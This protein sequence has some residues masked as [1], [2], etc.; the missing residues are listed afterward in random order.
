MIKKIFSFIII[1]FS[2]INQCFCAEYL[3]GNNPTPHF[4]YIEAKPKELQLGS[5][6]SQ[7]YM[8]DKWKFEQR[9]CP[10]QILWGYPHDNYKNIP[11]MLSYANPSGDLGDFQ[12][13]TDSN[14]FDCIKPIS[15]NLMDFIKQGGIEVLLA[16]KTA[17]GLF[18]TF[19][20][21]NEY[22]LLASGNLKVKV[23][24]DPTAKSFLLKNGDINS[25]SPSR[26]IYRHQEYKKLSTIA[27]ALNSQKPVL[28]NLENLNNYIKQARTLQNEYPEYSLLNKE[29]IHN[30]LNTDLKISLLKH[31]SPDLHAICEKAPVD[32]G[33][34]LRDSNTISADH[35]SIQTIKSA[36]SLFNENPRSNKFYRD[37]YL[38]PTQ[39]I[40]KNE[41]KQQEYNKLVELLQ[42]GKDLIH[43]GRHKSNSPVREDNTPYQQ[44]K[45]FVAEHIPEV[46]KN[47]F[48][49]SVD[50]IKIG[51]DYI[52]QSNPNIVGGIR[53]AGGAIHEV[54]AYPIDWI[55]R[56][57]RYIGVPKEVAQD[58]AELADDIV[59]FIPVVKGA[60]CAQIVRAEEKIA[61]LKKAN[62]LIPVS[63]VANMEKKVILKAQ[64]IHPISPIIPL[65]KPGRVVFEG[66]EFRAVRNLN[67][68]SDLELKI[69]LETGINPHD[70]NFVRLDGHHH[71]QKFHRDPDAFIVE[72]P[73]NAHNI[74][75]KNQHP[76]GNERGAGLTP[77]QRADWNKL[78][79]KFNKE[80]AKNELNNRL[81]RNEKK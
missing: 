10:C 51:I 25:I 44:G 38:K 1:I 42:N 24:F 19:Y 55:R 12:I 66:V 46:V 80:R 23:L 9:G 4:F 73:Q 77:T 33:N 34:L 48:D 31:I 40:S 64:D 69:M 47:V 45:Q 2:L 32:Q 17:D 36:L 70:A 26:E 35:R 27:N 5:Q 22:E 41:T 28:N 15:I 75:N 71:K 78:R 7:A 11:L 14:G 56:G 76:K 13:L 72:I 30:S 62:D 81:E 16:L 58:I 29:H 37:D 18:S 57:G 49:Y 43:K 50:Q 60:K 52:E 59:G 68:M 79:I 63:I 6:N 20:K 65:D 53:E 8:S 3:I 67:H 21:S 74:K 61:Q 39:I 54:L